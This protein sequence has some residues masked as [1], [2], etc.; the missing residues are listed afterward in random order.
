MELTLYHYRFVVESVTDGDTVH[1]L[2]DLGFGIFQRLS[3]RLN[4]LDA[5]ETK[6]ATKAAGKTSTLY[7]TDLIAAH[8]EPLKS[9]TRIVVETKLDRD[10]K[11]GRTLAELWGQDQYSQWVNLNDKLIDAGMAKPWTGRGAKPA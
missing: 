9:G 3:L 4:G 2:I 5:P 6:G 1:G 10:D 8:G 11:Y 7:L